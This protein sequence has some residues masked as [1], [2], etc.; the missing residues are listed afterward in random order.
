MFC[1]V[2]SV[3]RRY[4]R[5]QI[6]AKLQHF[7]CRH[8]SSRKS[9]IQRIAIENSMQIIWERD[10]LSM[11]LWFTVISRTKKK[12]LY[13]CDYL[14]SV[15]PP[16]HMTRSRKALQ[17]VLQSIKFSWEW[18]WPDTS[19]LGFR[20]AMSSAGKFIQ[21]GNRTILAGKSLRPNSGFRRSIFPRQTFLSKK[22]K[23]T[24]EI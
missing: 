1:G 12:V 14:E 4:D 15:G 3:L 23:I 7:A 24:V 5:L 9:L 13:L 17:P 19:L 16:P 8:T 2:R 11:T 6:V 10:G 21:V 20:A 18:R 22:W